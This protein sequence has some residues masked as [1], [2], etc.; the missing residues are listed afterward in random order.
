MPH[1]R[2]E[3]L[4]SF[5]TKACSLKGGLVAVR[6]ANGYMINHSD[7]IAAEVGEIWNRLQVARLHANRSVVS[8][9]LTASGIVA[10]LTL[11]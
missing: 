11:A 7:E 9:N 10:E 5:R 1:A 8:A 3:P 2:V 6:Q 4:I